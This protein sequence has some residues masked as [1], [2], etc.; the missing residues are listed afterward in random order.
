MTYPLGSERPGDIPHAGGGEQDV[1]ANGLR[2]HPIHVAIDLAI[3]ISSS[4]VSDIRISRDRSGGGRRKVITK[5]IADEQRT[6]QVV[7]SI[8]G[9]ANPGRVVPDVQARR[10]SSVRPVSL[11]V[12]RPSDGSP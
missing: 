1:L 12:H 10:L 9:L 8:R 5:A 3:T 7:R 6:I 4:D 11:D 2:L